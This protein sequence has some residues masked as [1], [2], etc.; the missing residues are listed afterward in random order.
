MFDPVLRML[1]RVTSISGVLINIL[2][3]SLHTE[4]AL[5]NYQGSWSTF[6]ILH[7]DSILRMRQWVERGLNQRTE[8]LTPYH[9][10]VDELYAVAVLINILNVSDRTAHALVNNSVKYVSLWCFLQLSKLSHQV[11]GFLGNYSSQNFLLKWS[12]CIFSNKLDLISNPSIQ[13]SSKYGNFLNVFFLEFFPQN[14]QVEVHLN[15]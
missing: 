10:R 4:H 11:V 7:S 12:F 2:C 15:F 9:A 1:R 13:K 14:L 6:N 3:I 5:V 8:F